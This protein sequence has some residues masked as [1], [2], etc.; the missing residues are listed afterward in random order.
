MNDSTPKIGLQMIVAPLE[1]AR[2]AGARI[3]DLV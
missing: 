2:V 1:L 3:A